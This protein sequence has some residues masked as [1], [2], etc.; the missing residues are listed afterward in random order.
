MVFLMNL[1]KCLLSFNQEPKIDKDHLEIEPRCGGAT[2]QRSGAR[3]SNASPSEL[4]YPWAIQVIRIIGASQA[5]CGGTIIT[6]K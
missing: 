5:K 2:P 1:L 6:Q 3:V 4:R